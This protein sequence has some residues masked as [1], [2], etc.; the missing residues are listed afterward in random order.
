MHIS[1]VKKHE[2]YIA[3]ICIYFDSVLLLSM[4]YSVYSAIKKILFQDFSIIVRTKW[5]S[6]HLDPESFSKAFYYR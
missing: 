2:N 6:S 1:N 5:V 3:A 4:S